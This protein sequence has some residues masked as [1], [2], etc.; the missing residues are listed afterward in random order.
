MAIR[1]ND[2]NILPDKALVDGILDE[3]IPA[4]TINNIP[5]AG[6]LQVYEFLLQQCDADTGTASLYQRGFARA[7]EL[8]DALG[9][10]FSSLDHSNRVAIVKRLEREEPEFFSA[11]LRHTYMGYYSRGDVR[12][13]LGLSPA[14]VHPHGYDVAEESADLLENLT[15][16]VRERG[17]CFRAG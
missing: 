9:S 6:S 2:H 17:N 14:P 13:A 7:E 3:I 11:L 5:S 4:G 12:A 16:T 15:A 1:N 10:S 8:T